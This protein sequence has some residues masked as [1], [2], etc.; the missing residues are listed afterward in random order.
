[1]LN[2]VNT[3][4]TTLVDDINNEYKQNIKLDRNIL[5]KKVA[6]DHNMNYEALLEQYVYKNK[7]IPIILEIT[8]IKGKEYYYQKTKDGNVYDTDSN[9]IGTFNG[10]KVI[11]NA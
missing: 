11:L 2:E 6:E 7:Q 8:K 5:L 1:M 10:K 4:W 3:N 9:I